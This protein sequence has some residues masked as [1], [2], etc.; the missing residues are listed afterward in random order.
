MAYS[1]YMHTTPSGK[2]YIGITKQKPCD[3][4]LNGKGYQKQEYFYN[5]ILKYGWKNIKHEVL[6]EGLTKEEAEQKEIELIKKYDSTNRDKGYNREFGGFANTPSQETIEKIRKA[7]T[8]KKHKKETCEKL[9]E[10]EKARWKNPEYRRNQS[11]K[12]K[13]IEPWNKG[14]ATSD[15]AKAKQ[16][17]AKLGKYKG[18]DHWNSKRV[19]NLDTGKIYESFGQIAEEL[20]IT[21]ATHIVEVCKHKRP[22]AYGSRWA[23]YE[24]EVI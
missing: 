16:R 12:R 6:F 3:R 8:G 5:A 4:W 14:K 7:N 15:E 9:R 19:I 23:Y 2:V 11:E 21:N 1:V 17:A 20:Q 24:S 13:G 22:T 18:A 10:L